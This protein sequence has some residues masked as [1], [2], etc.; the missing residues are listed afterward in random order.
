MCLSTMF[1]VIGYMP[2]LC[3]RKG[4]THPHLGCPSHCTRQGRTPDN[5]STIWKGSPSPVCLCLAAHRAKPYSIKLLRA[6]SYFSL[7][8]HFSSSRSHCLSPSPSFLPH[9]APPPPARERHQSC[10][11]V[12]LATG[13]GKP[14]AQIACYVGGGSEELSPIQAVAHMPMDKQAARVPD[15][16]RPNQQELTTP[17]QAA[18][19]S[20]AATRLS[21]IA[22]RDQQLQR[23][24]VDRAWGWYG[25]RSGK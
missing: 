15:S 19:C 7:F 8:F 10:L 18:A 3:R 25:T 4:G 24:H 9:S 1:G 16:P 22:A 17:L 14:L 21:L 23:R 12:D 2:I 13:C 6:H 11:W 20:K 5:Y